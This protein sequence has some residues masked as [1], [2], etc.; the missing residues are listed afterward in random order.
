[1][2]SDP[3]RLVYLN[4]MKFGEFMS[5][6]LPEADP[7]GEV[8]GVEMMDRVSLGQSWPLRRTQRLRQMRTSVS[9]SLLGGASGRGGDPKRLGAGLRSSRVLFALLA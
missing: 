4:T 7:I 2:G 9:L 5:K 6:R 1:M 8:I 3:E